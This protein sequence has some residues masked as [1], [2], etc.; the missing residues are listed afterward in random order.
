MTKHPQYSS[1]SAVLLSL[2]AALP[3]TADVRLS[4]LF[5][6]HMV[7]QRD[8]AVSVWGWADE[9][10][11]VTVSFQ[12]QAVTGKANAE[13]EWKVQLAALKT[14][15]EGKPLTVK[16][17][18]T[19]KLE[20]VLVGEVWLCSGQSNMEWKVG[21]SVGG[22]LEKLTASRLKSLRFLTVRTPGQQ[23]PV[24]QPDQKWQPCDGESV[25]NFSAVGYYFGRQLTDTLN[26]PVGLIDNSWGGSAC[27]AWV[28][29]DKLES[30][31]AY[32]PL[33]EKWKKLEA[34]YDHDAEM[35]KYREVT[36]VKWEEAVKLA[37]T[38][39]KPAPQK[40]RSPQ[41]QMGGNQRPGNLYNG[42]LMP[43][44]GYGIRGAIWYQGES[45]A[46]RAFQYR[47][48]FPRMIKNWRED[49]KQGDFPFYWVQLA[50]FREE[51]AAPGESSWAELREAQTRTL[52]LPNSGEAVIVDLGEANDI[53]PRRKMEVG[54]RL[55][56]H[57]LAKNYNIAV[58]CQSPLYDKME[59]KDGKVLVTFKEVGQ[60]LRT[61]DVGE[62]R[63]FAIAGE[64][65]QW[66]PGVA[67]IVGPNLVEVSSP[68][69]AGPVAVRYAW[70]ENP[71]CNLYSKNDLP[72]TPFRTDDWAMT[73]EKN[74]Q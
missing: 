64:D 71:V 32:G 48:L 70:A 3:A 10:E 15:A 45:N 26:V 18:N 21:S 11:E 66:K 35:K 33:M 24:S 42:R 56:R 38:E 36:L 28:R 58:P 62:V 16:G 52:S 29:R 68:Q 47:D 39:G 43:V 73:T 63:G 57:A 2:A 49:W 25:L 67:K 54:L 72:V 55:A 9:G 1:A 22:D 20:N 44:L 69:V 41:N 6:D 23:T 53:H 27:E 8:Q 5:S 17:K 50:D 61:L 7:L 74:V 30:E 19:V 4:N 60:G 65:K 51:V 40:P 37:K 31:A 12:D 14:D 13:G 59:V 46:G 34:A